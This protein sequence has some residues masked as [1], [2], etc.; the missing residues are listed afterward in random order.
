MSV[1]FEPTEYGTRAAIITTAVGATLGIG[2]NLAAAPAVRA[3]VASLW[4]DGH[5]GAALTV[6][7]SRA[8]SLWDYNAGGATNGST[9][10]TLGTWY[11]LWW[12]MLT[13]SGGQSLYI[14]GSTSAEVTRASDFPAGNRELV[15]GNDHYN[16]P[17]GLDGSLYRAKLWSTDHAASEAAGERDSATFVSATGAVALYPLAAAASAATDSFAGLNLTIT[18]SLSDGAADPSWGGG[19]GGGGGSHPYYRS[20][21]AA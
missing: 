1:R 8:L 20:L 16:T 9:I 10:L 19:G 14:D 11:W 3:T 6:L 18:G 5:I 2:L 7:P 4:V 13:G 21:I 12:R 15:L 17:W